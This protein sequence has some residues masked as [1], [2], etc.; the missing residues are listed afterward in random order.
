MFVIFL[1]A[2]AVAFSGAMMPGPLLTYTIRQSLNNGPYS[3]FIIIVGHALLEIILIALIFMG[4]NVIL[5]SNSAQISIGIVGGLLLIY[6]GF[7]MFLGSLKN[8]IKIKF[9]NKKTD[10]RNMLFS[11]FGISAVNPYFLLWWA[12]IGLGFLIQAY[13]SFGIAGVFVY[14]IGHILADF[15]W[16]GFISVIVGTT[17]RFINENLYRVVLVMLGCL[18]IFFGASFVYK[19][20]LNLVL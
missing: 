18:L 20:I 19:A 14:Y 1:S 13:K 6:M 4:F 7:D 5:Q 16:Y 3:G 11:G 17:R 9:D 12:I 2:L 15:V 10:A 8:R